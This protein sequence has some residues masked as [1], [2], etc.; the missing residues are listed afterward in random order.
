MHGKVIRFGTTRELARLCSRT[1]IALT[2]SIKQPKFPR[3][4]K[5]GRGKFTESS[6]TETALP[7]SVGDLGSKRD[8]ADRCDS[9]RV[10][11]LETHEF[12][13]S[14]IA[15]CLVCLSDTIKGPLRQMAFVVLYPTDDCGTGSGETPV[16]ISQSRLSGRV[17]QGANGH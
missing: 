4:S 12:R 16:V 5:V 9:L 2:S 8:Q 6:T 13:T 11:A 15:F 17:W 1:R 14:P 3:C 10:G 7:L